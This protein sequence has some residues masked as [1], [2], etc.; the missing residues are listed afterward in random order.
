MALRRSRIA[1]SVEMDGPKPASSVLS[2][3]QDF[4]ALV[5]IFDDQLETFP[6][7]DEETRSH[8]RKAKLAAQRGAELS[9]KLLEQVQSKE[10][11]S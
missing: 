11:Q 4:A 6:E 1:D 5:E 8:L 9:R 7:S 3:A 10:R 2:V